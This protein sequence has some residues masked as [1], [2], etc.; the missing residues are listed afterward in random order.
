MIYVVKASLDKRRRKFYVTADSMEEA[1]DLANHLIDN[2]Y[3]RTPTEKNFG[4]W[5]K[6]RIVVVSPM[7]EVSVIKEKDA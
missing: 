2:W 1:V 4:L 6:G 5:S 3:V 7:D